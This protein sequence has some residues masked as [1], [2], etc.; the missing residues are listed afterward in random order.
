M[1][2]GFKKT[3]LKLFRPQLLEQRKA[4]Q[5]KNKQWKYNVG[6]LLTVLLFSVVYLVQVN[7][8]S[9]KGYAIRELEKRISLNKKEN[10]HIQMQIIEAQSL[11]TLQKKIDSLQLVRSERIDYIQP[12][13]SVAALR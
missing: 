3:T 7:A 1:S 6:L 4:S 13:Q 11:G 8:L 12:S 10:E 2:I 5:S 9:T